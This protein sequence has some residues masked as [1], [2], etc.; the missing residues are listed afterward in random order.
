MSV[1]PIIDLAVARRSD[2]DRIA[3]A[4][5]IDEANRTVGFLTLT[6]HGIDPSLLDDLYEVSAEFFDLPIEEKSRYYTG[7]PAESRGYVPPK[8][9]AL[10]STRGIEGPADLMEF[11]A[12]GLPD[13]P[14]DDPYFTSDA[15]GVNFRPN[16]W[17]NRPERFQDVWT[18]YYKAM[19]SLAADVMQL[20]ALALN[21]PADYFDDKI[22]RHISNLFANHYP[23][24]TE[25]P[26]PG[27]LRVG[28]HTDYGSLT[29]LYQRD[30]VGGLEVHVD[31]AWMPVD[32]MPDAYVINIGDLMARW[33]NDRWV[34]TLHRVQ[35]PPPGRRHE[36][37][38]SFPF[39]CQPNY[40]TLIEALPSCVDE[41]HPARY[42]P[43]TSGENMLVKTEQSLAQR[44]D[45]YPAS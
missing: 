13:V 16:I 29:L 2:A 10:A 14:Q 18:R 8:N 38:I 5:R 39:F 25:E 24:V 43:I 9:R 6:N 44:A 21:L 19:E 33:T 11:F 27:Q 42:A 20:F 26:L 23:P 40:D 7:R 45:Q 28:E 30:D 12:A 34:S 1:V 15:A 22:D 36:R 37:R 31:G 3:T 32:A 35:V 41:R 17:P 4:R